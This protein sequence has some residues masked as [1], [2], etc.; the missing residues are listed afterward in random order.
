[1]KQCKTGN[2]AAVEVLRPDSPGKVKRDFILLSRRSFPMELNKAYSLLVTP[3][4]SEGPGRLATLHLPLPR[5]EPNKQKH[6]ERKKDQQ[7]V[8]DVD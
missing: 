2:D 1:M 3:C 8:I 5:S 6:R 4:L 7:V